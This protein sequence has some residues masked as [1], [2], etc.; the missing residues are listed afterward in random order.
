M[1]YKPKAIKINFFV[2]I[3]FVCDA[4]AFLASSIQ[5][6]HTFRSAQMEN[7]PKHESAMGDIKCPSKSSSPKFNALLKFEQIITKQL[8]TEIIQNVDVVTDAF[9]HFIVLRS[10]KYPTFIANINVR[11]HTRKSAPQ[12][13]IERLCVFLQF[14]P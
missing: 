11:Q 5:S 13:A 1:I 10:L 6:R 3:T 12:I 8:P 4:N 7:E 9:H 2:M 14:K